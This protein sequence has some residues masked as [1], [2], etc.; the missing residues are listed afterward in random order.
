MSHDDL[1]DLDPDDHCDIRTYGDDYIASVDDQCAQSFNNEYY[2]DFCDRVLDVVVT[3]A[4]KGNLVLKF[5]PVK[6]WSFLRR[7]FFYH[8][9]L[10]RKVA[11][12]DRS[13]IVRMFQFSL[14]SI[15]VSEST[16]VLQ[17]LMPALS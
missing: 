16:Q 5:T 2:I 17:T 11:L 1:K 8:P 12:L 6:E 13:S 4:T 15:F 10:D 9:V 7:T 3:P 14:P